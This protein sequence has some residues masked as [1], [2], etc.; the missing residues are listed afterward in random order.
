MVLIPKYRHIP[1]QYV[2]TK[3]DR[4]AIDDGNDFKIEL[5]FNVVRFVE[6]YLVPTKG[7]GADEVATLLDWQRDE[8]FIPLYSWI[9]PNGFRLKREAFLAL[10][11]QNGKSL[12]LSG[13]GLNALV[14]DNERGPDILLFGR[15]SEQTS[16]VFFEIHNSVIRSDKLKECLVPRPSTYE[17]FYPACNGRLKGCSSEPSSKRGK[18]PSLIINDE[19]C[20]YQNYD[21]STS[22]QG[23]TVSRNQSL[24]IYASTSGTDRSTPAYAKWQ[25][26]KAVQDSL[27]DDPTFLGL[28]YDSDPKDPLTEE[29]IL[30]CNPTAKHSETLRENLFLEL[31]KA[32]R[33]KI[34]EL[35]VRQEH[36]GQWTTSVNQFLDLDAWMA[37]GVLEKNWPSLTGLDAFVACDLSTSSDLT[38]ICAVILHE[39]KYWIDHHSFCCAKAVERS[40]K[41][42]LI[43][44]SLFKEEGTMTEHLGN[45]ID[46]EDV[47]Q[48]IRDLTTKYN[49][50]VIAFDPSH[51]AKDTMLILQSEGLPIEQ[52]RQGALYFN[53]PM[54]RLSELVLDGKIAHKSDSLINWQAQNLEANKD[55]NDRLVPHRPMDSAKIDTFVALLMAL[56]KTLEGTA[57]PQGDPNEIVFW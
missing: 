31:E 30:K 49:V 35:R 41:A 12:C 16:A 51:N 9:K 43:K 23:G 53:Q 38:S 52:Y 56:A 55:N 13:C 3:A 18:P 22:V 1:E 36:L 33:S 28:V 37:C 11:R 32:R 45:C 2:R 4:R 8:F 7:F 21:S 14:N 46:F 54:R 42:N 27:I 25:Y 57:V 10:P 26:A 5:G 15:T 19:Y 20:F 44:Y 47:R 29:T 17:I 40:V 24:T 50:R 34:E 6:S 48:H 39:G